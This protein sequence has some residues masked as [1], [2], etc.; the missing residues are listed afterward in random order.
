ME[1]VEGDKAGVG[2]KAP[3]MRQKKKLVAL[4]CAGS[5]TILIFVLVLTQS[6]DQR[7]AFL[8]QKY[9]RDR[10]VDVKFSCFA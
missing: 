9:G 6:D 8:E 10:Y 1:R 2:S 3:S 4:G 7:K 5:V